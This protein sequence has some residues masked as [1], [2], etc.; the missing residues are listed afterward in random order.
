MSGS[1]LDEE[2]AR[3][4]IWTLYFVGLYFTLFW[5]SVLLFEKSDNKKKK[6]SSWPGVTIV[7]PMFNEEGSIKETIK[8]LFE[9]DYPKDKLN[10]I[11]VNDGSTD[12]TPKILEELKKEFDITVIHQKNQ[13]KHAAL[14]KGLKNCS[15]PFFACLDAD[16]FV[17]K[18]SL[19][20]IIEDFDEDYVAAVLPTMIVHEPQNVLQR[21][22]W[23]EYTL[24]IFYKFIM[25]K[26]DCIHVAPGP[27]SVYRTDKVRKLGGFREAHKTEDLEMAL[28]LQ[29]N[30]Y[31]IKQSLDAKVHTKSPK[32]LKNF[33][34]QR[35]RWYQGTLLNVKDYRHFLFNRKYGE[36]GVF[37]MPLVGITGILSMIGVFVLV[38]LLL[39]EAFFM[40]RRWYMTN[41]D[42]W[43]YITSYQLNINLLA[44]DWRVMFMTIVLFSLIFTLIYL[45]FVGTRE[46]KGVIKSF[47][48]FIMFLYYFIIYKFLMGY[49]WAKVIWK[50]TFKKA[51]KWDK[52]N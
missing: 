2:I 32:T 18:D 11:C 40:V 45:A 21:V 36:F 37:H 30:H 35:T 27:F 44:V 12:N 14:N 39:K 7:V 41:F 38:Y 43:T 49:I 26:V 51:N 31:K 42:F 23:L 29:D 15:D 48:Y 47:K 34:G 33:I 50:L 20:R 4:I 16:S 46:R 9:L 17:E 3:F 10:V 6:Y 28:R 22:Q 19:K 52:V 8:K 24:N 5:L 13:G 25:G 1:S